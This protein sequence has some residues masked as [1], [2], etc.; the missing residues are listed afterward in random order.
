[1]ASSK[2]NLIGNK[3][4]SILYFI[5]AIPI[6]LIVYGLSYDFNMPLVFGA[7][8]ILLHLGI[9]TFFIIENKIQLTGSVIVRYLKLSPFYVS[10]YLVVMISI[11]L[12]LYD[13]NEF[14]QLTGKIFSVE[15]LFKLRFWLSIISSSLLP[16]LIRRVDTY[17]R[18]TV[19]LEERFIRFNKYKKSLKNGI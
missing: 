17:R 9:F 5:S 14:S 10:S 1:M 13:H 15:E 6:L 11:T 3:I 4:L 2:F 19:L 18:K 8:V 7:L 16:F 12:L